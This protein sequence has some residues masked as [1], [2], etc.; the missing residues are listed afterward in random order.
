M[1]VLGELA[2]GREAH[3]RQDA[4]RADIPGIRDDEGPR[5]GMQGP[6][7]LRLLGVERPVEEPHVEVHQPTLAVFL[8]VTIAVQ[9]AIPSLTAR[10]GVGPVLF[11]GSTGALDAIT[12]QDAEGT[13]HIP[14]A[15]IGTLL[16]GPGGRSPFGGIADARIAIDQ[17]RLLVL[18]TAWKLDVGGPKNAASEVSQ[19]KVIVPNMAQQVIDM[20]MQMH[21]GAGMTDDFPLAAMWTNARALRLADGPDEV[22]HM[23]VGRA[24]IA[25]YA[26]LSAAARRSLAGEYDLRYGEAEKQTLDAH[27]PAG[28]GAPLRAPRGRATQPRP[29][30]DPSRGRAPATIRGGV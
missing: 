13:T 6:E 8:V 20:A 11:T 30:G 26:E 22:H 27:R 4:R 23:V 28:A 19:I 15:T 24:E 21:G 5:P 3:P 17:A 7:P 25:R 29:S 1:R 10:F 12:A 18:N 16:L 2:S 9:A 14:S